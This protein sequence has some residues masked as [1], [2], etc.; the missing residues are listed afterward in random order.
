MPRGCRAWWNSDDGWD[1]WMGNDAVVIDQV[2]I[3]A[4][5]VN[6]VVTA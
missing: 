3:P 6:M 5:V 1:L 4:D 2:R